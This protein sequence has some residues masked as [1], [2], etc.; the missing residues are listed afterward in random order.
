MFVAVIFT[1][2]MVLWLVSAFP[3]PSPQPWQAPLASFIPWICVAILGYVVFH[4]HF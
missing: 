4:G 2:L 1:V 3:Y